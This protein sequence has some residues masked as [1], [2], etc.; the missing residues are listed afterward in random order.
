MSAFVIPFTDVLY[1]LQRLKVSE[2]LYEIQD[3]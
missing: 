1:T 3:I 2:K